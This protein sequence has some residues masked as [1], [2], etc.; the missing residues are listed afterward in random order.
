MGI[1]RSGVG[2]LLTRFGSL[3]VTWGASLFFARAFADPQSA[4]GNFYTFETAVSL[5][6]L[7]A[8]GGL[9]AAIVKR[10]SETDDGPA[11]AAAGLLLSVGFVAVVVCGALLA[12]PVFTDTFGLGGLSVW[13]AVVAVVAYQVK[14]TLNAVLAGAFNVGRAG[15][16]D[17]VLS[18]GQVGTQVGLL[19]VGVGTASLLLGFTVGLVLA[20]LAAVVVA[21]RRI[22]L[23]RPSRE[24][25]VRLLTFA[26]YSFLNSFTQK[27]YDN[28]DIL[29]IT[30]FLGTKQT[31]IYGIGFRF[32]LV[33]VAVYTA[34]NR[35]SD[36]EVSNHHDRGNHDR[37]VEV[38]AD[39]LLYGLMFGLPALAGFLALARP[40]IVTFYTEQFAA[41]TVVAALAVAS[42]IPEGA[43]STFTTVLRGMDR[44]DT[45]FRGG[46]ILIVTNAVLDLVLVPTVGIVGAVVASLVGMCLQFLYYVVHVRAVLPVSAT[47]LPLREGVTV[48]GAATTTG[49]VV[50]LVRRAVGFPTVLE[51]LG[52]VGLGVLVYFGQ[53]ITVSASLRKRLWYIAADVVPVER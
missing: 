46:A 38:M 3:A 7:L 53:V 51:L 42:R 12:T 29:V 48:A 15:G 18:V 17:L 14:D 1:A 5:L 11:Y 35:A 47:D 36:P 28:I 6:V 21:A 30:W 39:S 37:I 9:N 10:V 27:F 44:P 31:G 40:L 26:R 19:L 20:A 41:A 32:S 24:Q 4:M 22:K 16:V 23:A 34:I 13:L 2:W 33:V 8:N 50:F 25:F 52:L 45:V 43:R 49:V